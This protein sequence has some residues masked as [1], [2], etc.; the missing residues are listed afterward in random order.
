M[1]RRNVLLAWTLILFLAVVLLEVVYTPYEF[2]GYIIA[3]N[4]GEGVAQADYPPIEGHYQVVYVTAEQWQFV[5]SPH[6]VANVSG[7]MVPIPTETVV[8]AGIPVLF[9]V[10][11]VDVTHGFYVNTEGN[12][13][14]Q[15]FQFGVMAVPGYTDYVVWNFQPSAFQNGQST[16]HVFCSEYCG[17]A[18]VGLGHPWMDSVI[19]VVPNTAQ[20]NQTQAT[21]LGNNLPPLLQGTSP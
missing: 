13:A 17:V 10:R 2:S 9:I 3:N 5:F 4:V 1:K 19:T 7:K 18:A 8:R 21:M 14:T 6:A 12:F 16:Y 20:G 15:G 11:S